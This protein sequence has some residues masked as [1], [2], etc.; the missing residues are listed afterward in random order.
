VGDMCAYYKSGYF[1]TVIPKQHIL[2]ISKE[3]KVNKQKRVSRAMD[4]T[5]KTERYTIGEK[6]RYVIT[7]HT[8][9]GKTILINCTME[10]SAD[11]I[12]QHFQLYKHI[13][14]GVGPEYRREY[15][16]MRKEKL[17]ELKEFNK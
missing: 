14:F 11:A 15:K 3:E 10:K 1:F 9:Y 6:K 7:I 2:W 16:K 12:M 17:Q 13:I 5:I 4:G 8:L